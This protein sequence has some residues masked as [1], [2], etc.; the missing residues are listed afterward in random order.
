MK[1]GDTRCAGCAGLWPQQLTMACPS[2]ETKVTSQW[3]GARRLTWPTR[4]GTM[5]GLGGMNGAVSK[6]G[7]VPSWRWEGE[8]W[9]W[10]RCG[11]GGE[12]GVGV[13]TCGGGRLSK[14]SPSWR[15]TVS[16]HLW[17]HPS[18]RLVPGN[19]GACLRCR[20]MQ[21]TMGQLMGTILNGRGTYQ[22]APPKVRVAAP[23]ETR[24]MGGGRD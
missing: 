7:V 12:V 23:A 8:A 4:L 17:L 16:S 20:L 22:I 3:V 19:L 13:V 18:R 11:T 24:W 15:W 14:A 1:R 6:V 21:S 5:D 2:L 9:S 10:G